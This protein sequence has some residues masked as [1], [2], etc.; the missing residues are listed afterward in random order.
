MADPFQKLIDLLN[1]S[2]DYMMDLEKTLNDP[3]EKKIWK[4][5]DGH[6]NEA[7]KSLNKLKVKKAIS[8]II[9]ATNKVNAQ[10]KARKVIDTFLKKSFTWTN[11][12]TTQRLKNRLHEKGK[13]NS[14]SPSGVDTED[15]IPGEIIEVFEKGQWKKK[16]WKPSLKDKEIRQVEK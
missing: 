12:T 14:P 16:P 1:E 2:D 7:Y 15:L 9:K 11:P 5:I 3:E 13:I 8:S 10:S 4:E 6:L